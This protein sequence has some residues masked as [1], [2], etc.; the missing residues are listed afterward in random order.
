MTKN[1]YFMWGKKDK[2]WMHYIHDIIASDVAS[3]VFLAHF[4]RQ[5]RITRDYIN[6]LEIV[7]LQRYRMIRKP[8]K[9]LAAIGLSQESSFVF[10][11]SKN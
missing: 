8:A 10:V 3:G 11:I 5:V 9:V 2:V 7:D 6:S 1:S 4:L